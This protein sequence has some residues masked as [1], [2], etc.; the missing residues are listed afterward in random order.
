MPDNSSSPDAER[1]GAD[2]VV[3]DLLYECE[4]TKEVQGAFPRAKL[5]KVWDEIHGYRLE[6]HIP[7]CT[8]KEWWE[9]LIRSGWGGASLHF[10]LAMNIDTKTVMEVIGQINEEKMD[11]EG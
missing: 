9:F 1:Y 2:N 10:Q 11:A 8:K 7:N 6:V 3:D 4:S 5:N